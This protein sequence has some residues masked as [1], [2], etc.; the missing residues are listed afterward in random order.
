MVTATVLVI[1]F[2]PLFYVIIVD[3]V[4]AKYRK[5]KAAEKTAT[6]PPGDQ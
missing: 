3:K 2:S 1:I 4:S 5:R 6:N